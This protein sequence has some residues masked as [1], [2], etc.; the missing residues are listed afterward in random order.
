MKKYGLMAGTDAE[1]TNYLMREALVNLG[2]IVIL[3]HEGR[4]VYISEEYAKNMGISI[5][6]S[7]GKNIKE[8]IPDT[9]LLDVMRSGRASVGETYFRNGNA[10]WVNRVPLKKDGK[11]VGVA[12]QSILTSDID[13]KAL[14]KKFGYVVRQLNYYKKKYEMTTVAKYEIGNIVAK[15][16]VMDE[17]KKRLASV[18][19]TRSTV[20]LSGESGTGKEVFANA[21]HSLS[22]RR[23]KPFV[24][25]NCAAIPDTLLES[26]L[27]GYMEGAFTGA[28]K[29]GKIGDLEAADGGTVFMDEI[30]SLSVNMQAKLLRVIQEKEIKKVGGTQAIPIDVRFI[31]A[32]NRNLLEMIGEG[33]FRADFYY[34]INVMNLRIPPLRERTEDIEPLALSFIQ[35]FNRDFGKDIRGIEPEAL[36]LLENYDWPGNVRELENCIER[37]FNYCST[38]TIGLNDIEIPGVIKPRVDQADRIVPLKRVREEAEAMAI[39]RAIE[40]CGGNKQEAARRL[41]IDRSVLYDKIKKY[42]I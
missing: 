29:G 31:F 13:A 40:L 23:N 6:D 3:D 36:I 41:K 17:L 42:D 12:A 11:L 7:L 34:R 22:G 18:A 9:K 5:E 19:Q 24:K 2:E 30:N 27:F 33:T 4:M 1:Y 14:Q 32:T 37:A 10:F 16:Q 25:I 21:L 38:D 15:S 39:R 35:K 26:E 20:L 8:V 28:L